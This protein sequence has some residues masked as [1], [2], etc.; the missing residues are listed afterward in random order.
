MSCKKKET[1]TFKTPTIKDLAGDVEATRGKYL[2]ALDN[3]KGPSA[4]DQN[5]YE[6]GHTMHIVTVLAE[7][8]HAVEQ[9]KLAYEEAAQRL[10]TARADEAESRMQGIQVSLTRATWVIAVFTFVAAAGA[11]WAA[12]KAH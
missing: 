10:Q 9:A 8:R 5:K 7:Q 12:C 4:A 11:V 1:E 3:A 2:G 6:A